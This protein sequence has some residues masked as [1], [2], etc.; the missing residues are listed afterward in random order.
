L[1]AIPFTHPMMIMNNL[2]LGNT[3]MIWA[4]LGYLLLFSMLTIYITVRIYNSDIL[5]TG[6]IR[7][8][9]DAAS[10]VGRR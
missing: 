9:K 3:F 2:M 5:L 4:G 6:L 10:K 1:F 7:K 8:K